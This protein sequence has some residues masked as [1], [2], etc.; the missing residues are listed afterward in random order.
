MISYY[1]EFEQGLRDDLNK[2]VVSY[3]QTNA[4]NAFDNKFQI[5][6][7]LLHVVLPPK[8]IGRTFEIVVSIDGSR[9]KT[10]SHLNHI[11]IAEF[12]LLSDLKIYYPR[13][14]AKLIAGLQQV[15]KSE[16]FSA[17]LSLETAFVSRFKAFNSNIINNIYERIQLELKL[18]LREKLLNHFWVSIT[19]ILGYNVPEE[20]VLMFLNADVLQSAIEIF[21]K[22]QTDLY[23]P[24]ELICS[25][26]FEEVP[27]EGLEQYNQSKK[28]IKLNFSKMT[29]YMSGYD[30]FWNAEQIILPEKLMTSYYLSM[31]SG[32]ILC[33]NYVESHANDFKEI[34]EP[35]IPELDSLFRENLNGHKLKFGIM[36]QLRN[37]NQGSLAIVS[38]IFTTFLAKLGNE[39]MK[40]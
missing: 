6:G 2:V 21:K 31:Q 40:P 7:A 20:N 32:Y 33:I 8:Q 29:K 10:A 17:Y 27:D 16:V 38:D 23:S 39:I 1:N 9:K 36:K 5:N 14:Y 18:Q 37:Y 24:F 25:L 13:G 30:R 28:E 11:E 26:I 3:F 4:Q 19:K 12:G 22:N 34:L 35:I 15:L